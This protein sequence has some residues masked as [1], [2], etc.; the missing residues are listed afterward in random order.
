MLLASVSPYIRKLLLGTQQIP[1]L[2]GDIIHVGVPGGADALAQLVE[3]R[4]AH[5]FRGGPLFAAHTFRADTT[6]HGMRC[7]AR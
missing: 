4:G 7:A 6:R 1:G 5:A 3:A 2:Q